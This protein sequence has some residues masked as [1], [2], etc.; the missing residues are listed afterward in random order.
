M[1]A[2]DVAD[3][4]NQSTAAEEEMVVC[5]ITD[6]GQRSITVKPRACIHRVLREV[7]KYH[8]GAIHIDYA[9]DAVPLGLS[10]EDAG[11]EPGGRLSVRLPVPPGPPKALT[12]APEGDL[13][14]DAS[15]NQCDILLMNEQQHV[16]GFKVQTTHPTDCYVKPNQG[17][18]DPF[19][20]ACEYVLLPIHVAVVC[21]HCD[22]WH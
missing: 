13:I 16:M 21:R 15:S 18:S 3:V 10:F 1:L 14:I 9:G 8:E 7:M 19:T 11:I 12:I 4:R 20:V 6:H 17:M 2:V 22:A 5:L